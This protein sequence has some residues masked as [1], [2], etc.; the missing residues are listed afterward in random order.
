MPHNKLQQKRNTFSGCL[1]SFPDVKGKNASFVADCYDKVPS[2]LGSR[3]SNPP[4]FVWYFVLLYKYD[5]VLYFIFL[6]CVQFFKFFCQ[7]LTVNYPPPQK[8][9]PP[10]L[11][12]NLK[13]SRN[14]NFKDKYNLFL[15]AESEIDSKCWFKGVRH[16]M[17]NLQ[18]FF[19][20]S[21]S[22]RP[23]IIS[24]KYFRIRLRF[25]RDIRFTKCENF[26]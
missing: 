3:S 22:S 19:R 5:H 6:D 4:D 1:C 7:R 14:I 12:S 21:N 16:A 10:P 2:F 18:F 9:T 24:L 20:D 17:F 11:F 13:C 23:L 15:S 25:S 26:P 8:K